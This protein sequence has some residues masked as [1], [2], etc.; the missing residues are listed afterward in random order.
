MSDRPIDDAELREL[1]SLVDQPV[2]QVPAAFEQ[3]LANALAQTLGSGRPDTPQNAA[4][5]E[6]DEVDDAELI[7]FQPRP[8]PPSRRRPLL[9]AAA[10]LLMLIGLGVFLRQ[11]SDS[12]PTEV[13]SD[14]SVAAACS[15][16][17]RDVPFS[18]DE[19]E[20]FID[21]QTV[22]DA[23]KISALDEM[24]GSLGTLEDELGT[25]PQISDGDRLVLGN[26]IGGL[27]QAKA[28]VEMGQL[29]RA[30]QSVE[31]SRSAAVALPPGSPLAGCLVPA[32]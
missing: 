3:T 21:D 13:A 20:Q 6:S 8:E 18:F 15:Q 23:D 32:G 28:E 4:P 2:E 7:T 12:S 27:R 14:A 10:V 22:S 29:D 24:I 16:F 5:P 19:L 17:E 31:S 1:L 11:G 25:S 9:A 26:V 30:S